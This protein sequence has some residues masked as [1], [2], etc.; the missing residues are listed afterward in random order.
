[1]GL[2]ACQQCGGTTTGVA[3]VAHYSSLIHPQAK[4][5]SP[6]R[7]HKGHEE[8]VGLSEESGFPHVQKMSSRR[9]VNANCIA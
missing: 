9:I 1:V 8:K 3:I 2:F 7:E 6:V 4:P 5:K